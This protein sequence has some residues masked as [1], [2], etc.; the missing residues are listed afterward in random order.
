MNNDT[1]TRN[2]IHDFLNSPDAKLAV[3]I[4]QHFNLP[5]AG[6]IVFDE[7]LM[8]II[9]SY[10]EQMDGGLSMDLTTLTALLIAAGGK[11]V[12]KPEHIHEVSEYTVQKRLFPSTG[13]MIFEVIPETRVKSHDK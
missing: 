12:V 8:A 10:R 2:D 1:R 5:Y 9:T 7:E 6:N 4:A 3:A 13:A 11:V